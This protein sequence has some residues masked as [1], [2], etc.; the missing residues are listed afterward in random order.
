MKPQTKYIH[1]SAVHNTRAAE[2]VLP[3]LFD[4]ISP[5]SVVDV[6]CG[7]GTWLSVFERFGIGDLLGVEGEYLDPKSLV[8][9]E[10]LIRVANLELPLRI[11]RRF[12][13]CVSLEVGEHLS[14]QASTSYV[15]SLCDLSDVILFSAAI[16][17]QTGQNH[18]N[19][20]WPDY[21]QR[22][23][24]TRGYYFYD[25]FRAKLWHNTQVDWWYKQNIFL[26]AKPIILP[27][28]KPVSGT[29][30]AYIH[31]DLFYSHLSGNSSRAFY[32]Y[33]IGNAIKV[34]WRNVLAK[35]LTVKNANG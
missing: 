7:T 16:P 5:Q 35:F 11:D 29:V 24:A 9:Q 8:I 18:I 21:W 28:Q 25:L 20:Q 14:D 32:Q 30:P 26:V 22:K 34:R 33:V 19:E 17:G 15:N 10:R 4:Y 23:F 1:T 3:L 27:D 31:P 2:E 13:L 6:G 12:D